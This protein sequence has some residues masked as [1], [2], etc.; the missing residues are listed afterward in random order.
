[1][2]RSRKKN[3]FTGHTVCDSDKK[4][5]QIANR[6]LR[7]KT[8]QKIKSMVDYDDEVLLEIDDVSDTWNFAKD[9]KFRFNPDSK[10]GKKL[11]RK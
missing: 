11:I 7:I 6:R 4:D 10:D 1:M 3:P 9:G 8:R 5:K 2:S